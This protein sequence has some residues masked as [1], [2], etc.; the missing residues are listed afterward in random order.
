MDLETLQQLIVSLGLGMLLGF[1]RERTESS[2]GGIRT[3]PLIALLG[4]VCARIGGVWM[5]AAG[6]LALAAVV[7]MANF[8]RA[9]AGEG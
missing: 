6:L 7:V 1:Q 2:L 5:G 4:T 8:E 9:K 3:F